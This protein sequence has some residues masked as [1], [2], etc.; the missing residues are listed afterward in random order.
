MIK[1]IISDLDGTFLNEHGDFNR[2]LFHDIKN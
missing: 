1:L 2:A